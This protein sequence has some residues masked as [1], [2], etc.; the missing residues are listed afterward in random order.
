VTA[1]ASC[2][3]PGDRS[4]D[5]VSSEQ[6][7][8]RSIPK[9]A[10][11]SPDAERLAEAGQVLSTH[12][13]RAPLFI[14]ERIGALAQQGDDAGVQRWKDIARMLAHLMKLRAPH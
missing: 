9:S 1:R 3:A 11:A 7:E 10:F 4:S 8:I 14:A 2:P 12:G 5:C 6:P 13:D